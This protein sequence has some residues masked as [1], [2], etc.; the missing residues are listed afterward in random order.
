[1]NSARLEC[2][3]KVKHALG[4]AGQLV[5]GRIFKA[6]LLMSQQTPEDQNFISK[7]DQATNTSAAVK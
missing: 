1:M 3:A 2:M 5:P 7:Y 6:F 4:V